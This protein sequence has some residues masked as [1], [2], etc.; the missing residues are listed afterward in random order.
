MTMKNGFGV[1]RNPPYRHLYFWWPEDGSSPGSEN[2]HD[3]I[4]R[5]ARE[6]MDAERER[7]KQTSS[8]E[9]AVIDEEQVYRRAFF[10]EAIVSPTKLLVDRIRA[11]YC[12]GNEDQC[13]VTP[14]F[15]ER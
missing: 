6:A 11:R 5:M 10:R 2:G 14:K 12:A 8:S 7:A 9:D 3:Q 13:R 4:D 15:W 1:N